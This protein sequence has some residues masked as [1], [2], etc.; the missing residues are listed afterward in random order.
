MFR[1]AKNGQEYIDFLEKTLNFPIRIISQAEE[2][3]YGYLSGKAMT[4]V[5]SE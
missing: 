2:A 5:D 3:K 4:S 1:K